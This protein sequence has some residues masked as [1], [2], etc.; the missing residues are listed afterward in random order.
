LKESTPVSLAIWLIAA[1]LLTLPAV[2]RLM[3]ED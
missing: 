3:G 1:A 2:M